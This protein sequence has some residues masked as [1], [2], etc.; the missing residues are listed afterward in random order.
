MTKI[1]K[2]YGFDRMTITGVLQSGANVKFSVGRTGERLTAGLSNDMKVAKVQM[3]QLSD[4]VRLRENETNQDR[5]DRIEM[6]LLKSNSS[7]DLINNLK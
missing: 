3:Q 4:W 7:I 5:F 6:V 1:T 2:K